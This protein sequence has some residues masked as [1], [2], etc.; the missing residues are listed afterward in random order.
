MNL[1][2]FFSCFSFLSCIERTKWWSNFLNF[3]FNFTYVLFFQ[4]IN[5]ISLT[6]TYMY[7]SNNMN[8]FHAR[9]HFV[10]AYT[11]TI[12]IRKCDLE[13]RTNSVYLVVWKHGLF[14]C[15]YFDMCTD[16]WILIL[17]Y[18]SRKCLAWH[19]F[20]RFYPCSDQFCPHVL[21]SFLSPWTFNR[22]FAIAIIIYGFLL[23]KCNK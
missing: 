4:Q 16:W 13:A 20:N 15:E 2:Y 1:F 18:L 3:C 21:L 11:P 22:L 17:W 19:A 9:I 8:P 23:A 7:L 14:T 10:H 12:R 6:Y 5:Q